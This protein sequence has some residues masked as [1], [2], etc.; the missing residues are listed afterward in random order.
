MDKHALEVHMKSTK[1][2]SQFLQNF[3]L[4]EKIG[5]VKT[6]ITLTVSSRGN[7]ICII[8]PKDVCDL[9]RVLTGDMIRVRLSDHYR[10][11]KDED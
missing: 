11:R 9:N 4:Y 1:K 5:N 10:R 6:E 8:I 7:S 2:K 3:G